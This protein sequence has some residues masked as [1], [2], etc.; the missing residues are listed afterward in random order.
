MG[1]KRAGDGMCFETCQPSTSPLV[2]LP[3]STGGA[4]ML[5]GTLFPRP[6]SKYCERA[7]RCNLDQ[8][9]LVEDRSGVQEKKFIGL[10]NPS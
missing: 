10:V 8:A 5:V 7:I 2:G 3:N 1:V 6:V 9:V 4:T